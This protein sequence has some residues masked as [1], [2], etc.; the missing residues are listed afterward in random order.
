LIP[1]RL[2][3]IAR[4]SLQLQL[5]ETESTRPATTDADPPPKPPPQTPPPPPPPPSNAAPEAAATAAA[6]APPHTAGSLSPRSRRVFDS[7][8]SLPQQV[9]SQIQSTTQ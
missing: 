4:R 2:I 9:I 3:L 6:S 8:C 1:F 7:V 5:N